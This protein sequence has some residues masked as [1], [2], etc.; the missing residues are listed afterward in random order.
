MYMYICICIE[1][2]GEGAFK[3]P[4]YKEGEEELVLD[5]PDRQVQEVE[6]TTERGVRDG[7]REF[8]LVSNY[9]NI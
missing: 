5:R 6:V 3:V 8:R 2:D 4:V 1:A 7:E 9:R